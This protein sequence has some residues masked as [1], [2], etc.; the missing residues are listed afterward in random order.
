M[1][2]IDVSKL[3]T[4]H[5][6]VMRDV[7][8]DGTHET[9]LYVDGN[10]YLCTVATGEIVRRPN[11]SPAAWAARIVR[12]IDPPFEPKPGMV[13]TTPEDRTKK[14]NPSVIVRLPD[15]IGGNRPWMVSYELSVVE[16]WNAWFSDEAIASMVADGL[17]VEAVGSD[18]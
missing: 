5:R 11:G 9:G 1:T 4:R 7:H 3:T 6:L 18:E 12:V 10:D 13:L 2:D 14:N 17:L 15:A 16:D 8:G